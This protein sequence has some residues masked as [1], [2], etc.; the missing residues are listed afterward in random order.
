[1]AA[2]PFALGIFLGFPA[3]AQQ[4][5]YCAGIVLPL[6]LATGGSSPYV[7]V[8]LEQKTGP[9]LIDYGNG[10]SAIEHGVWA[11]TD[12]DP[13]WSGS[14]TAPHQSITL[15]GFGFPGWLPTTAITFNERNLDKTVPGVG[16][17]HGVVGIDLLVRHGLEFH[18]GDGAPWVAV[19]KYGGSCDS[20]ALKQAGFKQI[21]QA[22]HWDAN[23][24]NPP[25][26]VYNG[27]VVYLE[28]ADAA[29][30]DVRLGVATW[31]Q[32]DTGYEDDLLPYTVDINDA[33]FAK[34]MALQAPLTE[35]KKIR[36]QGCTGK[37]V[38]RRVF[39]APSRLLRIE[40]GSGEKI[41]EVAT[42][43]FVLKNKDEQCG[44]ISASSQPAGQI[45]ASFL[46]ALKTTIFMGP[47]KQLWTKP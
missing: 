32:F 34:L 23:V 33:L 46:R 9:F 10:S 19:S 17:Q 42:F 37:W 38:D 30:P 44:G 11:F 18:Y 8:K 41:A 45:G 3:H 15:K 31:A 12:D 22:G 43:H 36:V 47:S 5:P 1:L 16:L 39:T 29:K 2:L 7:D 13:R 28:L 21:S 25:D 26:G 14:P 20:A 24:S 40:N 27:P 6:H 35:G 4:K